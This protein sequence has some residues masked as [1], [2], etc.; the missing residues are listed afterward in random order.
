LALIIV[1]PWSMRVQGLI[2]ADIK[3][4]NVVRSGASTSAS[5]GPTASSWDPSS[6]GSSPVK[7]I[8]FG[9]CIDLRELAVYREEFPQ[10]WAAEA[11]VGFDIQTLTYRAPEVAAGVSIT[12]AV[13]LWSLGC[14]LVECATGM[15]LFTTAPSASASASTPA[16]SGG[17]AGNGLANH[18]LLRQIENAVNEGESL[19]TNCKAYQFAPSYVTNSAK[20]LA[21]ERTKLPP[22]RTLQDRLNAVDPHDNSGFHDFVRRL[23]DVDPETR[24][25]AREAMF[26]PFIQA[27]F[28]FRIVFSTRE[29]ADS[30]AAPSHK[31]P[32]KRRRKNHASP[33]A[34]AVIADIKEDHVKEEQPSTQKLKRLK[35]DRESEL[36]RRKGLRQALKLIPKLSIESDDDDS[37][38]A[39]R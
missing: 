31:T 4:E 10:Q 2:H 37:S 16:S 36:R 22:A 5:A 24:L 13:D 28:P 3:P 1:H 38:R 23:L 35:K 20:Q 39:S 14:V 15:P 34:P 11:S 8:D 33:P 21:S 32:K 19:D 6:G 26:H 25:K 18:Q 7:I 17:P 27:F 29:Q 9:N 30:L 12:P